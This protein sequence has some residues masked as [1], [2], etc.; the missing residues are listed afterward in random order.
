LEVVKKANANVFQGGEVKSDK[1]AHSQA[2][3]GL[4]DNVGRVGFPLVLASGL[5]FQ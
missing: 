4:M 3:G 2:P 1:Q 5:L